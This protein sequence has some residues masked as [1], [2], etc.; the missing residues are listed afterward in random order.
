MMI[1]KIIQNIDNFK[2]K[3]IY[4]SNWKTFPISDLFVVHLSRG[5]NKI[6]ELEK[7]SI[8]LV[9]ATSENNGVV[10]FVK[11]GDGKAQIFKGESITVDMFGKA[12]YHDKPFYAVSHGRVNILL[13][14]NN[15]NKYHGL[16]MVTALKNLTEKYSF[17][18]MCTSKKIEKEEILLPAITNEDETYSPDWN[19]MEDYIKNIEGMLFT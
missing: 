13:P 5:D 4:I 11:S 1:T 6:K 15:I 3:Q 16:F 10:G 19:Y 2:F 8:P 9:S 18:G 17:S 14:I 7:G 12:F